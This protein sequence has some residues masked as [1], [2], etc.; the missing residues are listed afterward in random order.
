MLQFFIQL[1]HCNTFTVYNI[2]YLGYY[3]LAGFWCSFLEESSWDETN[4]HGSPELFC[5]TSASCLSANLTRG[6]PLPQVG[7]P[8]ISLWLSARSSGCRILKHS[9]IVQIQRSLQQ[10]SHAQDE[11]CLNTHLYILWIGCGVEMMHFPRRIGFTFSSLDLLYSHIRHFTLNVCRIINATVLIKTI[12]SHFE[13][14][15]RLHEAANNQT[16]V[17]KSWASQN[18]GGDC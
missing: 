13:H 11:D 2:K 10:D 3:C 16:S 12:I 14:W 15:I 1:Y 8:M 7:S 5:Y 17:T 9:Y 6:F 18:N 4:R